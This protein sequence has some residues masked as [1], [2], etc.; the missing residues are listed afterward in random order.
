MKYGKGQEL[1]KK[2]KTLIPGGTQL[3]SKRPEM[4]L[5]NQWPAYY[6][7]A[8]GCEI[9]TLDGMHYYDFA[10]MGIGCCTL[11][12]ADDEVNRAVHQVIGE[13][14]MSS[15]NAPE[16]VELAEKL[17]ELHPW[18]DMVR[19]SRSGGEACAIAARIA[20]AAA[21]KTKIAFC[22]YFGWH[23]WYIASNLTDSNSLDG[24]LLPGLNAKGID[25]G[26]TG[27]AIPFRYNQ[28]DELENIVAENEGEIGVIYMEPQRNLGP[29]KGFLEGV[30][31][32]ADRIGAILVFDEVTSGFRINV[33][34]IHLTHGVLPDIAVFGKALGNG[35]P[36]S[37]V[38]GKESVMQ[39]AQE[40]FISSTFW[41]ERIGPAAALATLEKMER[42]NVPQK[43]I[44]L[45][46]YLREGLLQAS[47]KS[48]VSISLNGIAP[49][50]TI[51]FTGEQSLT[52]QTLFHQ[53]M[54]EKGFLVGGS[55]YMTNAYTEE[56]IDKFLR[57]AKESMD[58]IQS[59][60]QLGETEALL[61]GPIKHAGFHRLN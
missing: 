43:L 47:D 2:A 5:P 30:R 29:A 52:L 38:I 33:G 55:L 16:E 26:L 36:V 12:Y 37:A 45:G 59:A 1:Y 39:S 60:L 25:R 9:W 18:A 51:S 14:A 20:R 35:F 31:K 53:F 13:G 57:A 61:K 4:Y 17:I 50:T 46:W 44:R 10:S 54:M 11:G 22:G 34:G 28:L 15:L 21:G 56:I 24:Q 3:L 7:K 58:K 23:D 27:S 6:R 42:I 19:F 48:E 41:T 8:K 49:L 40:T 32:L